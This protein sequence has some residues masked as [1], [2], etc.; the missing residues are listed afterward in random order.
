MNKVPRLNKDLDGKTF[1]EYYYLK[2]E[3]VAFCREEGLIVIG[4]K[5]ELTDRIAHF[6]D[7]GEKKVTI[8]RKQRKTIN[9]E[10]ITE[11]TK[12]EDNHR[13]TI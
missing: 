3:L 13:Q 6:L 2:E 8:S 1:Q 7:T 5:I 12:I 10:I 9:I 4:S 11:D